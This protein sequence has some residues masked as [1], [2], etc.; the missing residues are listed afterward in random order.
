MHRT[1]QPMPLTLRIGL[2]LWL[3]AALVVGRLQWL[4]TLPRPAL[5]GIIFALT[6]LVP[7]VTIFARLRRTASVT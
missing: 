3:I 4:A 6:G 2:W 5:Q 7:H 1:M